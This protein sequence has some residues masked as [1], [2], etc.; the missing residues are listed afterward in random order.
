MKDRDWVTNLQSNL[1]NCLWRSQTKGLRHG[2]QP[3]HR[4]KSVAE[5]APNPLKRVT[6]YTLT[7][8]SK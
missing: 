3:I 5:T 6:I 4:L 2:G 8:S 7:N 1:E